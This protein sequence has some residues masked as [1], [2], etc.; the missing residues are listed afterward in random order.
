LRSNCG[1]KTIKA[2][3]KQI[4]LMSKTPRFAGRLGARSAGLEP[5]TF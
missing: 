2:R 1:Q 5:A 3:K 4:Y